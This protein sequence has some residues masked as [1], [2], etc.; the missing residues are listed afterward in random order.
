MRLCIR[1]GI[2]LDTVCVRYLTLKPTQNENKPL[3]DKD[4][5]E[6]D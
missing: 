3:T 5:S 4:A 1:I 6:I 2:L